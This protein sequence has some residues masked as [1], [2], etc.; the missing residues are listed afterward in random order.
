MSRPSLAPASSTVAIRRLADEVASHADRDALG[1]LAY[2]VLSRQA[3][4]KALFAGRD[5][6]EK[7]AAEHGVTRERAQIA[8]GN[9]LATLERGAES[10]SERAAVAAFAVHGFGRRLVS[11]PDDA[12]TTVGRLVRHTDWLE[13][14]T[15][16][17]VLPFVDAVL[18]A[19]HAA[20]VWKE[21]AHAV[22]DDASGHGGAT[23]GVRAR[24]AA[25]LS[26]LAASGATSART[27][28]EAVGD[29]QGIDTA[30]RALA[31]ALLAGTGGGDAREGS[32]TRGR[33]G[34]RLR[35]RMLAPRRRGALQ[36]VRWV[37]G[38]ALIAWIARG[39]GA[40]LGIRRDAELALGDQ[41]LE[42]REE[43]F[44]LGRKVGEAVSRLAISSIVEAGREVRYPS[45][46]L[47]IG[48][49][50]LSF[51]L[52]FGGLV[53]FDGARSGEL[54]LMLAGAALAL[55]G[56][57]L[58]LAL[59]VLVPARRGRV[60]VDLAVH[61]GRVVRVGRVGLD[62]ADRFLG[63]LRDRA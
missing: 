51:G 43:R 8:S 23:A 19:E 5:F 11:S 18:D 34:P 6:V 46:H 21:I 14:A 59:D 54:T 28:L 50:A 63:A 57:G 26:A 15:P 62:E 3:E 61:R 48:V 24:N 16:Y 55:T 45:L 40:L 31:I 33:G 38:W 4:G 13:L 20:V 1:A 53:L 60:S 41:G 27:A 2:D 12:P 29:T 44:V 7:R 17:S 22:V 56:A 37:S 36:L 39:I 32:A 25:R 9:L 10:D 42:L 52:L 58:D 47:L 49:L 35:G 30:T